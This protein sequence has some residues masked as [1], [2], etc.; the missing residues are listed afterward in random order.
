MKTI[1]AWHI[2]QSARILGAFALLASGCGRTPQ[3]D[4]GADD[5]PAAPVTRLDAAGPTGPVDAGTDRASPVDLRQPDPVDLRRPDPIDLRQPDPIDLRRPDPIDLRQPDPIDLRRPDPIDLRRPDPIDLRQPDRAPDLSVDRGPDVQPVSPLELVSRIASPGGLPIRVLEQNQ[6]VYLGDWEMATAAAPGNVGGIHSI[7]VSDPTRPIQL[8]TIATPPDQVQDLAIQDRRLFAAND[9]LGLRVVDISDPARLR[10]VANRAGDGLY[11]TA[12]AATVQSRGNRNQLYAM[13]GY[14][15]GGG[16]TIHAMPANGT[17]PVPIVYRSQ[18]FPSRCDV[19]QIQVSGDRAYILASNG[20]SEACLEI[21]DLA[22][23]PALPTSI[24]RA[25]FYFAETGGIGDIRVAGN[26]VYYAAS[27]FSR[28]GHSGGLR[29]FDVQDPKTPSMVASLDF[30]AGN[31]DW[32]GTGLT[33]AGNTVF[34]VT[35]TG[36][37]AIDVTAPARPALRGN[38][39]FPTDFGTCQGGTAAFDSGLL[40]VGAYCKAPSHGGLAIYRVR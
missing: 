24:G 40:Y 13:A 28:S 18:H 32:K 25:C 10:S 33:V 34:F 12:V 17:I 35:A 5:K 26:Y 16:M 27:D 3:L 14:L 7:D 30:P 23:L 21:L 39:P 4:I 29:V 8:S 19:H 6:V 2:V 11:A 22:S 20:E 31:I 38:S 37:Q 36:V 15:Y 1:N 9:A